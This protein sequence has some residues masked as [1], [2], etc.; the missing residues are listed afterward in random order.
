MDTT[1]KI[2]ALDPSTDV[3]GAAIFSLD[4]GKA[5][6]VA[7]TAFDAFLLTGQPK[8]RHKLVDRLERISKTRQALSAWLA[9]QSE[10]EC[11]AYETQSGRGYAASEALVMAVGAYLTLSRLSRLEPIEVN[12]SSACASVGASR[13]Y[14]QSAGTTAKEKEAKRARLKQA[15]IAG[16]NQK[17]GLSLREDQDAEADAIAVGLAA[18]V[19]LERANVVKTVV[20]ASRARKV[21]TKTEAPSTSS[22][23]LF[24]GRK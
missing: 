11:V 10:V 7:Y 23:L 9:S 14:A 17:L 1:M 19:Q 21:A 5:T 15:V 24:G 16:V 12:R 8:S 3:T 22:S 18:S 20:K 2:L 4:E 6:L 13:V